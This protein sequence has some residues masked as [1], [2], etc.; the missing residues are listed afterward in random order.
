MNRTIPSGNQ[1]HIPNVKC[2]VNS[3]F[4][5]M[6]QP[7]PS[8][9]QEAARLAIAYEETVAQKSARMTELKGAEHLS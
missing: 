1:F 5:Y 4:S 8:Q 3:N 6:S 2:K 9:H 7:L